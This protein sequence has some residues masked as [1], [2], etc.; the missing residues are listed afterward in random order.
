[1]DHARVGT[2]LDDSGH[3][4][5]LATLELAEHLV[6]PD[7]AESLVDDLLRGECG[8]TTEVGRVVFGLT[9]D[10]SL[11]IQLRNEDADLAGLAVEDDPGARGDRGLFRFG[12]VNVLEVGRQDGLFDD[13][14]EFLERYLALALHQAQYAQV[15]VH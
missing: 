5:T 14:H 1:M 15:D 9:D 6:V 13:L 4:V 10:G 3:D 2:L 11:V 8:D 12:L 7:I